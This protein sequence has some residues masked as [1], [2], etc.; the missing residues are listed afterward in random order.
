MNCVSDPSAT[1]HKVIILFLICLLGFGNYF[2]YDA[3]SAIE[4]EIEADM[5]IDTGKFTSLYAWYSWPNIIMCFFGGFLIDRVLGIRLGAIVFLILL[6]FGQLMLALGAF[7]GT[8]WV[9]QLGRFIYGLGGESLT[10]AQNTYVVSWFQGD[11]LNAVFGLQITVSRGGSALAMLT[12]KPI[13]NATSKYNPPREALG[14]TFMIAASTCAVSLIASFIL[15][16]LDKRAERILNRTT[17][18]LEE[19][20]LS[21]KDAV[22]FKSEFW[23]LTIICVTFYSTIF[24][25]ITMAIKF[26]ETKWHYE[27]SSFAAS[28]AYVIAAVLSP[29]IGLYVDK[30]GRNL[31]FILASSVMVTIAHMLMALLYVNLWVPMIIFGL[32]Y[33][34][35][36]CALWPLVSLIIP[37]NQLGTAY[38]IMQA[39]QNLGLGV[40]NELSGLLVD[41][42]GYILVESFFVFWAG[43]SVI[44][45]MILMVQ[46][47]ARGGCLNNSAKERECKEIVDPSSQHLMDESD[48]ETS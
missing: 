22:N 18:R 28:S 32:G 26:F 9:M 39:I 29:F 48:Q 46:D 15:A 36:C 21:I 40:T 13:Y 33:S 37:K 34:I 19:A 16:Y 47:R 11:L 41:W 2:C 38:G 23:M 3:P 31:Y 44:V 27:K 17:T 5:S 45:T 6:L 30:V 20:N 35:M 7:T 10:V 42:K 14:Y 25:F 4:L 1:C 24:P 12:V 8:F 43:I